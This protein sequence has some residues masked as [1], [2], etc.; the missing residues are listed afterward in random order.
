MGRPTHIFTCIVYPQLWYIFDIMISLISEIV[1]HFVLCCGQYALT[2]VLLVLIET[3]YKILTVLSIAF[4]NCF[5]LC[6]WLMCFQC[7]LIHGY[8]LSLLLYTLLCIDCTITFLSD[9]SIFLPVICSYLKKMLNF[10]YTLIILHFLLYIC[11]ILNWIFHFDAVFLRVCIDIS[12][13]HFEHCHSF[14]VYAVYS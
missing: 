10:L 2:F 3:A 7:K 1:W 12:C 4:S 6:I 14:M 5:S 11:S 8:Q 9:C 13:V